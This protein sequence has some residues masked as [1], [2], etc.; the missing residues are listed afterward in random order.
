MVQ[1]V[2]TVAGPLRDFYSSLTD[3][4]K[5]AFNALAA[6]AR[7]AG[8][9]SLAELCGPQNAVPL[10]AADRI[11]QA[12]AP[13]AK[14]QTALAAL[15]DAAGKADQAILASCPARAAMTPPGR[16][17]AIHARLQAMLAGV[18]LVRPA[19]QDF[20]ATLSDAQKTKF[21]A[22]VLPPAPSAAA[23]P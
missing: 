12:V 8:P 6:P 17:D 19:L 13:D 1:A 3:E 4:Q 7:T 2:E 10:I 18:D 20:Y 23:Q 15:S 9:A 22:L 16:L 5:A 11:T 21:D 14:Q